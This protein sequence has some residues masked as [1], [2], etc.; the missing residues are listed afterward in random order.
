MCL[1]LLCTCVRSA[2]VSCNV[3]KRIH[4]LKHCHA[5]RNPPKFSSSSLAAKFSDWDK[6]ARKC[7]RSYQLPASAADLCASPSSASAAPQQ[8]AIFAHHFT[9]HFALHTCSCLRSIGNPSWEFR[10]HKQPD[11]AQ[12][13][14]LVI[15][16]NEPRP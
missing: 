16:N 15:L 8:V 9:K 3:V 7:L 14:C 6:A 10:A 5:R 2:Y 12:I 13:H 1:H 4:A 11:S